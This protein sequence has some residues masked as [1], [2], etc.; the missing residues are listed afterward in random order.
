M[1]TCTHAPPP[2]YTPHPAP[3]R[4]PCS[5][6][7]LPVHGTDSRLRRAGLLVAHKHLHGHAGHR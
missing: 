2:D 7:Q 1:H 3:L 4:T 6:H 5:T